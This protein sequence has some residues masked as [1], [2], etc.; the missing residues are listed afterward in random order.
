[1][2]E[3]LNRQHRHVINLTRFR[4]ALEF[5]VERSKLGD[6]EVTLAFV[7][8][9]SIR[10]LNRDFRKIDRPTDVLS[11][12]AGGKSADGKYYLGDIIISVPQAF[13]QSRGE[14]HGLETELMDLA[15]HGF[16]HL[17]GFDHGKGIEAEEAEVR[18]LL[19]ENRK[20]WKRKDG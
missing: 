5:L 13:E 16:L 4:R 3:V 10:K 1:M 9:K 11:F 19:A 7:G 6:P 17:V 15:V 12:P 20:E 2:I 8:T 14:S 18:R